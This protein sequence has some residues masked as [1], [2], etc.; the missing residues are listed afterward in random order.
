MSDEREVRLCPGQLRSARAEQAR[1]GKVVGLVVPSLLTWP[2]V[3]HP[4]CQQGGEL[5]VHH[6]RLERRREPLMLKGERETTNATA[7]RS[8]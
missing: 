4:A 8:V 2:S 5:P 7:Q 6:W 1:S 3:C